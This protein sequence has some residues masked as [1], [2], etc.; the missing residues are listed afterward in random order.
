MYNQELND[1]LDA[2]IEGSN[3][4]KQFIKVERVINNL[5]NSCEATIVDGDNS[6]VSIVTNLILTCEYTSEVS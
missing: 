5:I 6:Q 3:F 1:K 2:T 4:K